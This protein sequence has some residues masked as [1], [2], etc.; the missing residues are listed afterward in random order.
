MG[1]TWGLEVPL[2]FAP[3]GEPARDELSFHRSNDFRHV[4]D[5][6]RAV[7]ER[8]GVTEIANFAKYAVTGPGAE[9]WLD[10]L[11]ANALPRTGRIALSP[12]LNEAGKLIG[13]F[14]VA[15]AGAG[16]VH[17][18]GVVGGADLSHALVRG[19]SAGGRLGR[20][21]AAG[22][23]ADGADAG[24]AAVARGAGGAHR[25]RRVER[26][27]PL[28]GPPGDGRRRRAGDGQPDQLHRRSRLRDLGRAGYLRTLYR[29]VQAAGAPHGLVDF[30]MR[31]LLS[32]RLEKNWPTWFAELRPIYGAFEG[33][34]ERFVKLAKDFIGREAAAREAEAGPRLRR[35]SLVDRGRGRRRDGRRADLGAGR[36]RLRRG[37]AGARRRA[38][39]ASTRRARRS[40]KGDA[41]RD[42]DWR[43]VG[44]VTSGG[45]GHSVATVAGA[46]LPA[47]GAGRA[48][49]GGALRGRDPR[50]AAAGAHPGRAAVRSG[51][52]RGCGGDGGR[53]ARSEVAS[54]RQPHGGES[55]MPEAG[56][57]YAQFICW[58]AM[59]PGGVGRSSEPAPRAGR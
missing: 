25:P 7:R 31:A 29:A 53:S 11:L 37:R 30:G 35:V 3:E 23:A 19:A 8:V 21:R 49:R 22:H 34:M 32:M 48:R 44:W 40:P 58:T 56:T 4:G 36:A 41:R 51:R 17:G 9:G 57:A 13:D 45:Y 16:A 50:R 20:G 12:M 54:R 38:R 24:R 59:R 42:G 33:G 10:R 26:R 14:T 52:Q 2:W 6:V 1:V 18:L 55:R 28:H 39:R 5:E 47:G 46:G 27:V 15:K 43:V